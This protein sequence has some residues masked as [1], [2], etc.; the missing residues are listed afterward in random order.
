MSLEIPLLFEGDFVTHTSMPGKTFKVV[1]VNRVNTVI[2]DKDGRT[3]NC[4]YG[5][6]LKKTDA[7][8]DWESTKLPEIG[9]TIKV[10][11]E[12]GLWRKSWFNFPKNQIFVVDKAEPHKISFVALG[13]GMGRYTGFSTT[14][15]QVREVKIIALNTDS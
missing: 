10:K 9:A 15:S 14:P 13:G 3:F 5:M 2:Q 7:P 8:T 1:K 4:R 12:S 11:P 6:G